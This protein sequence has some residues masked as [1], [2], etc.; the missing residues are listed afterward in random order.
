MKVL[1]VSRSLISSSICRFSQIFLEI[2]ECLR[3]INQF[4]KVPN[5]LTD[6]AWDYKFVLINIAF[7]FFN[8]LILVHQVLPSSSSITWS[9]ICCFHVR[10][11]KLK[12]QLNI[13][14]S[15]EIQNHL[16]DIFWDYNFAFTNIASLCTHEQ[17]L[18]LLI[19]VKVFP[20]P[21]IILG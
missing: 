17:N 20:S 1:P 15:S 21:S 4:S 3:N 9:S 14:Q 6:N 2:A 8:E 19:S 13:D 7:L 12:F 5:S 16:T 11:L 18:L 10:F